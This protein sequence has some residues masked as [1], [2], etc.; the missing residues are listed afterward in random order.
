MNYCIR[1]TNQ[2]PGPET[3]GRF[4]YTC[5]I[6]YKNIKCNVQPLFWEIFW[7][8]I[9]IFLGRGDFQVLGGNYSPKRPVCNTGDMLNIQTVTSSVIMEMCKSQGRP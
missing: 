3:R 7:R 2:C 9:S 1:R 4:V 6:D 5:M 8:G